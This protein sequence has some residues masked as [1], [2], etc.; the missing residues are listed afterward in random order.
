MYTVIGMGGVG[1]RVAQCFENYSQYNIICVDDD[2]MDFKDK[3]VIKKQ[4]T[5][6]QYEENFKTI[7]KRIKDKIK[8]D[9]IFVLSGSSIVSSIA[10][11]FLHQIRDRNITIICIRPEHDL[12]DDTE[13]MHERMVFSVL[14]E[15]TRSGLFK[16]IYL[17]SNSEMDNMVEDASIKEYY[18]AINNLIASMFHMVM[19]FDHQDSEVSN[20]SII[21]ESRRIC[22]LGVLKIEDSSE[23]LLFPMTDVMDTRLYYGISKVSLEQD[24]NLQ[25]NIIKLIKEKNQELC[26]YSYGVYQ[27]QYES[28][29]CYIKT[30]SSKVQEF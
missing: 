22:T 19:V 28:D 16:N 9:V 11:K 20:F 5:P 30:Y 2:P 7:P 29:F 15:Y 27:T 26:K 21:N 13:S 10:L 25:R 1:C 23:S 18:P 4:S 17:T 24:K 12:L 6:E 3:L 8:Q 14:Q